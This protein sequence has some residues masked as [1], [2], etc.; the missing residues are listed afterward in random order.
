MNSGDKMVKKLKYTF[1]A[2]ELQQ[3][4]QQLGQQTEELR[5]TEDQKSETMADFNAIIKHLK[6]TT[7]AL[8]TKLNQGYEWRD[9]ECV[10]EYDHAIGRKIIRHPD[11]GE[12]IEELPLSQDEMQVNFTNEVPDGEDPDTPV[13]IPGTVG[14]ENA[15]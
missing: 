11:T 6:A 9:V 8:S 4:G 1:D 2:E 7:L 10:V 12:A 15:N 14:A 13:A 3:M 5:A